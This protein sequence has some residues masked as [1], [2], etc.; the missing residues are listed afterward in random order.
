MSPLRVNKDSFKPK[1]F[2]HEFDKPL[3]HS[4]EIILQNVI[5]HQCFTGS[6]TVVGN[7]KFAHKRFLQTQE[8]GA[9]WVQSMGSQR[10]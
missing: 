8:R 1:C 10:V 6:S 2:P 4:I 5:I 3:A 7:G 9:R